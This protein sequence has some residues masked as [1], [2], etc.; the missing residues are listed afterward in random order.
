MLVQIDNYLMYRDGFI[1]TF[2]GIYL[3][4]SEQSRSFGL[5]SSLSWLAYAA[6]LPEPGDALSSAL[7]ALSIAYIGR[8]KR[9]QRLQAQGMLFYGRALREMQKALWDSNQMWKEETLAAGTALST[10]EL[11]ESTGDDYRGWTG[12][13]LGIQQLIGLRG[14]ERYETPFAHILY[15]DRRYTSVRLPSSSISQRA[16]EVPDDTGYPV[17]EVVFPER[18]CMAFQALGGQTKRDRAAA[19][20][21]WF[22]SGRC[23]RVRR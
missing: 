11:Y 5:E 17:P 21:H 1:N 10:Y 18:A 22:R 15:E 6:S 2:L 7:C 4:A 16:D 8:M 3:P 20:R 13:E 19:L 12:H 9:D 23:A 14:P